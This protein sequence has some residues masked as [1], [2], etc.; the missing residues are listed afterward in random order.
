MVCLCWLLLV[1]MAYVC[2][3]GCGSVC[4]VKSSICNDLSSKGRIL[5]CIH[6]CMSV[7]QAEFPDLTALAV[8]VG[9]DDDDLLFSIILAAMAS[10]DKISEPD[11]KARSNKR[12]SYSM[13][14]FRWGKPLGDKIA[15]PKLRTKSNKRRSYTMEHFRW[16]KPL[17]GK[18]P[19]LKAHSNSRR[20][21]S[22]EHFRWGKPPGRKRRPVKV[23]GSS[24]EGGGSSEDSFPTL[25]RRQ[26]SK[27][28]AKWE[29]N[30]NQ[31]LKRARVN[32][33][34]KVPLGPQDRKAGTYRMSH[35]RWGSPAAS[36]RK[37]GFAK[38]WQ[39]KRPVNTLRNIIVKDVQRI[40]GPMKM[41]E[42]EV[43]G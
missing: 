15:Q 42:E 3:P 41:R 13:E 8:K 24:L 6:C 23:F 27:D 10:K 9:G 36:K 33:T 26:L 17:G 30:Q 21:Y 14:H 20:S 7:I 32:S 35:F 12:R 29:R 37:D 38:P 19:K 28:E 4:S 43:G 39:E 11:L 16:G 25:S 18:P 31:Q 34:T 5:D 1:V 40:M 22:M 2:V